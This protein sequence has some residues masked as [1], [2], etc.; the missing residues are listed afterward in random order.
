MS[1]EPGLIQAIRGKGSDNNYSKI[2]NLQS[3]P[4]RINNLQ[5]RSGPKPNVSKN[6]RKNTGE[7]QYHRKHSQ[8][9]YFTPLLRSQLPWSL[10]T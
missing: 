2:S 3:P 1:Q 8:S 5:A 10:R 9:R 4:N 6:L 7:R